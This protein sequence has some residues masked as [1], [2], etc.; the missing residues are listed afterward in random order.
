MKTLFIPIVLIIDLMID[1]KSNRKLMNTIKE[2]NYFFNFTPISSEPLR[3][4]IK[5]G[6]QNKDMAK[7][8]DVCRTRWASRINGL[9][10][11]ED[12]LIYIVQTFE[13]FCLSS[14]SNVK[15]STVDK[16]QAPLNHAINFNALWIRLK[17]P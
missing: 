15:R 4:T 7:L 3:R 16:A 9:D 5:N 13:Y 1:L 2:M 14:D 11:F 17:H 8:F 6:S 12:I 10:V